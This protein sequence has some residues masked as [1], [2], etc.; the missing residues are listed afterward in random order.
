MNPPPPVGKKRSKDTARKF[1]PQSVKPSQRAKE[2]PGE[3]LVD[4]DGKLFCGACQESV[5]V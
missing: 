4:S 3:E 2:F 5:A 1:D